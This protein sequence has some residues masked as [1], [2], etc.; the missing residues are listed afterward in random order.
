MT[1]TA[2]PIELRIPDGRTY[3]SA[4]AQTPISTLIETRRRELELRPSDLVRR[5]GWS[6][7]HGGV[8][9]LALTKIGVINE[10]IVRNGAAALE[11]TEEE[12]ADAIART[13]SEIADA[14]RARQEAIDRAYEAQFK[15]FILV[16]GERFPRPTCN[17]M[18]W[19]ADPWG[20]AKLDAPDDEAD[21]PRCIQQHFRD[22]AGRIL[23]WGRIAGYYWVH[24]PGRA[25]EY[26]RK[27]H[28]RGAAS[29]PRV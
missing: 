28:R 4:F 21:V 25:I 27:G 26:T 23:F 24:H 16:K 29:V 14:E 3:P 7:I 11:I 17:L 1:F 20:P 6:N 5:L 10:L 12:L 2:Y 22:N 8:K 15:P 13:R 18:S 19:I 9:A